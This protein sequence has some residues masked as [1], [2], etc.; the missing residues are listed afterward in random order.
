[1][2]RQIVVIAVATLSSTVLAGAA[3]P[4][5]AVAHPAVKASSVVKVGIARV[6]GHKR[7]VLEN[8]KDFPL[9]YY[10]KDT[11][12][13]SACEASS[14]CKALWPALRVKRAPK[15]PGAVGTFSVF[16]GHLEYNGHLLYMFSGDHKPGVANGQ[17]Y[18]KLWWVA[19]PG[20]K[21]T[22]GKKSSGGSAGGW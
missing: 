12:T 16:K 3:Q 8:G 20:L 19:T 15:V 2:N 10:T 11:P 1:M 18:N 9:Y 22:A 7:K 13:H 6:K 17:G 21:A 14:V 4:R 5:G